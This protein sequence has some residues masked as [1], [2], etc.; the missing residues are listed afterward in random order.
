[1]IATKKVPLFCSHVVKTD[2]Q[3]FDNFHIKWRPKEYEAWVMLVGGD[4]GKLPAPRDIAAARI[5]L[6]VVNSCPQ[7]TTQVGC[8]LL[9]APF[10]KNKPYDFKKLGEVLGTVNVPKQAAPGAAKYYRIDVTR[11]V[12]QIAAGE[13]KFHGFCIRTIPNRSVD[14]GWTTRI[15][16]T[17]KEVT[18]LELD[19]YAK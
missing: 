12:K 11:A 1:P 16:I 17:K 4:L 6:P 2:G 3:V 19:A 5:C 7:A 9:E 18:Y 15:D 8:T 14:D 13:A 10:Q